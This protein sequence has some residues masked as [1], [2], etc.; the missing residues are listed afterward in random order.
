[1]NGV[2][3]TLATLPQ[4]HRILKTSLILVPG[5]VH[6]FWPYEGAKIQF[7][8]LDDFLPYNAAFPGSTIDIST[9]LKKLVFQFENHLIFLNSYIYISV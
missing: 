7:W 3:G 5:D 1:M 4:Q 9:S 2:F 6:I 8:L